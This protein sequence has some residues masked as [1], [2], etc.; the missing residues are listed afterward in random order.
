MD[1]RTG[2]IHPKSDPPNAGTK[3]LSGYHDVVADTAKFTLAG[4]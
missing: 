2:S 3:H 1:I 4:I